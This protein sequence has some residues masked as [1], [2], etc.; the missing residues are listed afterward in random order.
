MREQINMKIL[1]NNMH[2]HGPLLTVLLTVSS[3]AGNLIT[4]LDI[5]AHQVLTV[6]QIVATLVAIGVGLKTLFQKKVK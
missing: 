3:L 4:G 5:D 2:E 1:A 6:L